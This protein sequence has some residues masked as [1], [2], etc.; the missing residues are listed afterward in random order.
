MNIG[1][2]KDDSNEQIIETVVFFDMKGS[3]NPEYWTFIHKI[4]HAEQHK[5]GMEKKQMYGGHIVQ[6]V[7]CI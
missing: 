5:E 2:S 1:E 7:I 4:G 3:K 6:S